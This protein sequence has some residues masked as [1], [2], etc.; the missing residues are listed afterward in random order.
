MISES[1]LKNTQLKQLKSAAENKT[2]T[3]LWLNKKKFE[4]EELLHE[5]LITT[6][7]TTKIGNAFADNMSGDIKLSKPQISKIS[8][9]GW[10]FS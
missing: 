9:T 10:S 4:D 1:K 2:R 7:E 6:R 8:Q 3:K 5:L